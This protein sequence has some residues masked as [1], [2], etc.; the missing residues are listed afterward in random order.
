MKI[1]IEN[2]RNNFDEHL[3]LPENNR[4]LFSGKFGTGKS[5]FLKEYFESNIDKYC[6]FWIS[7]VNYVVGA[8]HDIFE[9]IKIDIAKELLSKY[10]N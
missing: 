6:M 7:P 5:H 1:S 9:W 2:P 4:I 10:L 3:K 8:N